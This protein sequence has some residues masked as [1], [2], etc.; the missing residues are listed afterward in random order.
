MNGTWVIWSVQTPFN[1]N[2]SEVRD[3][4]EHGS[5]KCQDKPNP[6]ARQ[7]GPYSSKPMT[8]WILVQ[9]KEQAKP[10]ANE[11]DMQ[12]ITYIHV[13]NP[14]KVSKVAYRY[15]KYAMKKCTVYLPHTKFRS[16]KSNT[17][18]FW[19]SLT[20]MIPKSSS[21]ISFATR[22]KAHNYLRA[23]VSNEIT[24]GKDTSDE[25]TTKR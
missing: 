4:L 2:F 14:K 7:E 21:K 15:L 20:G 11:R 6:Y 16:N 12:R 17:L 10:R 5:F 22:G 25:Y 23:K 18:L 3:R 19:L 24:Q 9:S 1:T 13:Y 8:V